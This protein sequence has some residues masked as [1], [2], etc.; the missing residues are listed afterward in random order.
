MAEVGE[1]WRDAA[2]FELEAVAERRGVAVVGRQHVVEHNAGNGQRLGPGGGGDEREQRAVDRADAIGHDDDERKTK[3]LGQIGDVVTFADRRHQPSRALDD[4]DVAPPPPELDALPQQGRIDFLAFLLRR[5]VRRQR[6]GKSLRADGAQI[7]GLSSGFPE[8][9]GIVRDERSPSAAA[10]AGGRLIDADAQ[11]VASVRRLR[12]ARPR[13]FCRPPYRC[14][15]RTGRQQRIAASHGCFAIW[16]CGC[17]S[18]HVNASNSS[19]TIAGV[20]SM[21]TRIE[22]D[23]ADLHRYEAT[24]VRSPLSF[25]SVAIS[26]IRPIRVPSASA[27]CKLGLTRDCGC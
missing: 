14:R 5:Q 1:N 22:T 19:L 27:R 23:N 11:S 15:R 7:A 16:N 26:R 18:W 13:T 8:R 10:A 4:D 17:E 12:F 2:E 24:K 6:R 25:E 20:D 9:E 21:R 3:M